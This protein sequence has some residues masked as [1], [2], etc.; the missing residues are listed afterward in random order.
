[1]IAIRF[2]TVRPH[3]GEIMITGVDAHGHRRR[4][5]TQD[6]P[7]VPRGHLPGRA[8]IPPRPK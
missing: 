8:G 5:P 6:R 4:G 1:M 2:W 3:H 7:V